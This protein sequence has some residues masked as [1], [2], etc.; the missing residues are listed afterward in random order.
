MEETTLQAG[1]FEVTEAK[2]PTVSAGG[3]EGGEGK[4]PWFVAIVK[5]NSEKACRDVLTEEGYQAYVATQ[6]MM[7]RYAKRRPK[8]VEYVRIPAKVFVRMTV[9][10]KGAALTAFF[11]LHPHIFSLMTDSACSREGRS[12][13]AQIPDSQMRE[14]REILG[15]PD[16]EVT[17]GYP[18]ST[19][20]LGDTVRVVRGP[21]R[22]KEGILA[23]KGGKSYFCL[24]IPNLDWAKVQ[25]NP[26]D[27]EPIAAARRRG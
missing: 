2:G 19:F 20:R 15:D 14:M 3:V 6:T 9:L 11:R 25:V 1:P 5:R 7:R 8:P 10:P 18:D 22:S 16:N 4:G 27:L 13:Y 12:V 24:M 17:F 23:F 21:L 26:N